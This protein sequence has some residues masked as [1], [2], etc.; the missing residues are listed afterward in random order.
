MNEF[1]GH[2]TECIND[3]EEEE[4]DDNSFD[5]MYEDGIN[6]YKNDKSYL[7]ERKYRLADASRFRLTSCSHFTPHVQCLLTKMISE[8]NFF[9]CKHK[10][11]KEKGSWVIED[12]RNF[13]KA[14][15][16]NEKLVDIFL[17]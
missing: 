12:F 17:R 14:F 16:R 10:D 11:C 4:I 1:T 9:Y 2:E 15:L 6:P 8:S 5:S 3:C 7:Q 13:I